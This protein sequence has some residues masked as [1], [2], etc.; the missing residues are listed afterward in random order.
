[1]HVNGTRDNDR[2]LAQPLRA[3]TVGATSLPA[4]AGVVPDHLLDEGEL[5]ILAIK[6]SMWFIL[7]H[8][9]KVLALVTALAILAYLVRDQLYELTHIGYR[10][11]CQIA[12][13]VIV[14]QTAVAFLH[15]MS[16]LY[17]L[18][19]RRVMRIRGIFNIDVFE[20][21]LAKIQNTYLTLA[22]HERLFAL[23][24]VQ[25]ATAGTFG[26]EATWQNVN[27]PLEVHELIRRT[28]RQ[29]Q[30]PTGNGAL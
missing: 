8:S 23:G 24:S 4:L 22:I 21:P 27:N 9:A 20:A 15:W 14:L 3:G 30:H 12:A 17:V 1:M 28:I 26:I 16:R 19:N 7:F 10:T 18:T 6:P 2:E 25:F 11:I 13:A 5:V 29:A